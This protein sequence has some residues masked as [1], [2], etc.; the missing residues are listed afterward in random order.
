MSNLKDITVSGV[1]WNAISR[2]STI[3]IQFLITVILARLLNP[4]DFGLAGIG[5]IYVGLLLVVNELGIAAPI[6]QK[7]EIREEHLSSSFWASIVIGSLICGISILISPLI[8]NFFENERLKMVISVLSFGFIIGSV[9]IVQKAQLNR[10]LNFKKIATTEIVAIVCSGTMSIILAIKGFG[11]WSIVWGAIVHNIMLSA[12]V[13]KVSPW[14]PKWMFHLKSFRELFSFGLNVMGANLVNYTRA[15]IDQLIVGKCLG[16]SALGIYSMAFNLAVT[17]IKKTTSIITKVLF[18]A[19]SRIQTDNQRIQQAYLKIITYVSIISFPALTLLFI[20]APEFIKVVFGEKWIAAVVPFRILCP[21]GA[22]ISVG[23][24]VGSVILAKGRSDI[25]LKWNLFYI[26]AFIIV[27][28]IAYRFGIVGIAIGVLS[29]HIIG[30]PIIQ[31]IVNS[32]I[33][34]SFKKY[35][36]ALCPATLGS[37][38]MLV[39]VFPLRWALAYI[40]VPESIFFLIAVLSVGGLL[41]IAYL[42]LFYFTILNELFEI[43]KNLYSPLSREKQLSVP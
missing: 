18:P 9:G 17:P 19:F 11:V 10:E 34:L 26:S 30:K 5:I 28:M 42:R 2:V 20:I 22:L 36:L 35:L 25:E 14:R 3:A 1:F 8:A 38:C 13:W 33:E 29:L 27:L 40:M 21:A 7:K 6:I 23:T 43:I 39:I 15:N 32:L 41:H 12:L 16:S 4:A 31:Y 37:M 24:T